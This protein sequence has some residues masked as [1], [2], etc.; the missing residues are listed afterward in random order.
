MPS[1]SWKTY[2]N[3]Y[4]WVKNTYWLPFHEYVPKQHESDKRQMVPYYQWVPIILLVMA[5]GF[6]APAIIWRA[7]N[8]ASGVDINVSR[9]MRRLFF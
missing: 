9:P 1:G 7:L 3:S 8:A 2:T 5:L 4:C 6:H